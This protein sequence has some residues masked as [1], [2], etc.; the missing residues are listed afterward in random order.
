MTCSLPYYALTGAVG[1]WV[2]TSPPQFGAF[3]GIL[4][5]I[6]YAVTSGLPII[7]IAAFGAKLQER[8]PHI[9][10][11]SDFTRAR[12]GPVSQLLIILLT[13]F[14]MSIA[15]MAE[16]VSMGILFRN[17]LG[18]VSYGIIIFYGILT[19]LYV[20]LPSTHPTPSPRHFPHI[21]RLT[22]QF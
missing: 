2:I 18:S 21:S 20:S 13:I 19:I 7:M 22:L 4:G 12:F 1:A 11:A 10:S 15:L 14:N 17:F 3:T 9:L 16:Y 5:L 6:V 8:F